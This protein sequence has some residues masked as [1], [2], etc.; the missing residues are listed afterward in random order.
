ME[1]MP[2][3]SYEQEDVISGDAMRDD[4]VEELPACEFCEEEREDI[5]DMSGIDL[6]SDCFND[7]GYGG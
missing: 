1:K 6:C 7:A 3:L 4:R 2:E 5:N